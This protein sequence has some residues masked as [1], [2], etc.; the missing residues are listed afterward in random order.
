MCK[1][2]V[3]ILPQP[4]P[5]YIEVFGGAAWV[6]FAKPVSRGLEV[7]NDFNYDLAN[8]FMCVQKRLLAF[9]GEVGFLPLNSRQEFDDLIQFLRRDAPDNRF[10][11]EEIKLAKT[12]FKE[13]ELSE[14]TA[15]LTTKANEYD[16]QRAAAF[17][18]VIRHSYG[19][20]CRNFDNRTVNI[21]SMLRSLPNH[22]ECLKNVII[23]NM[24]FEVLIRRYDD[25]ESFFYCDPPYVFTEGH[26]AVEFPR[27]DHVR[28]RDVLSQIQ[29]KFLLSYNDCPLVKE[30]YK[31]FHIV[32]ITRPNN[33]K[34]RYEGG[35]EFPEVFISNYD[36]NE[37]INKK[38]TQISM[39]QYQKGGEYEDEYEQHY[40][41]DF[42][43]KGANDPPIFI[44]KSFGDR[45]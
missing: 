36:L 25:P 31:D 42:R 24:D 11:E 35:S 43:Q 41:K 32:E 3:K 12:N 26:Y 4:C 6:L 27:E 8:L 20:G 5:R 17:Y 9:T 2:I 40:F 10:L 28:L 19:S 45:L 7:Y 21:R 14:L 39:F 13:P 23:E 16:V 22:S 15:L 29:G 34:Q 18:K 44:S 37:Q 33:L 30:L 38:P 1:T